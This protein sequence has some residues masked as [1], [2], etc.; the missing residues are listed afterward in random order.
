MVELEP[1]LRLELGV[2]EEPLPHMLDVVKAVLSL[3]KDKNTNTV[4]K[5]CKCTKERDNKDPINYK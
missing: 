5:I 2:S 3:T 1:I 4:Y